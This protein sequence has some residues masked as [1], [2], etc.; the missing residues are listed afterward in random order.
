MGSNYGGSGGDFGGMSR[1][2]VSH[3]FLLSLHYF[4][5]FERMKTL[6]VCN[7]SYCKL[8]DVRS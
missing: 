7:N 6:E 8:C 3:G 1:G 5:L 4:T 2:M